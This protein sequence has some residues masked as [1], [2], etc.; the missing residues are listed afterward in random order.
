MAKVDRDSKPET[1]ITLE[2]AHPLVVAI[3]VSPSLAGPWLVE[4]IAAKQVRVRWRAVCPAGESVS[5]ED[6]G[7]GRLPTINFADCSVT[8]LVIAPPETVAGFCSVALLGVEVV[9]EDIEDIEAPRPAFPTPLP[10]EIPK[11]KPKDWV[12]IAK[13]N[14]PRRPGETHREWTKRMVTLMETA[15]VTSVWSEPNMERRLRDRDDD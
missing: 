15:Q 4:K 2:A 8:K 6:F 7:Q 12:R 13:R 3:C 5:V 1:W 11:Q 9:R 10:A 14:H